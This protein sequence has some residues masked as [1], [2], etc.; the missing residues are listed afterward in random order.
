MRYFGER[1]ENKSR[2][3]EAGT[4][5]EDTDWWNAIGE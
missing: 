2:I 4:I 5:E 3:E 1:L